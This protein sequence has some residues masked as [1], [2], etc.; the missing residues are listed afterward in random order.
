MEEFTEIMHHVNVNF[1]I[2]FETGS[3]LIKSELR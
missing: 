2:V 1:I 3:I